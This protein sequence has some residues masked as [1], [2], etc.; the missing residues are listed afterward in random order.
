MTPIVPPY[1]HREY[2]NDITVHPNDPFDISKRVALVA[3]PFLSLHKPLSLPI[4]LG[5]GCVRLYTSLTKLIADI[6]RGSYREISFALLGTI[7]AIIALASSIFAHPIGMVITTSQDIIL[8]LITLISLIRQGN[9]EAC[10]ISLANCTNNVL[11]LTLMCVGGLELSIAS[12]A[13]QAIILII[14]SREEFKRGHYLEAAANVL[15]SC[16]RM[17][18]GCCKIKV[19]HNEQKAKQALEIERQNAIAIAKNVAPSATEDSDPIRTIYTTIS[20]GRVHIAAD[21]KYLGSVNSYNNFV[22]QFFAWIFNYSICVNFDGKL[23]SLN[24]KSYSKLIETLTLNNKVNDVKELTLFRPVAEK[25]ILPGCTWKM[26]DFI[27]RKDRQALFQKLCAAI[28]KNNSEKAILMIGK[29]AEVDS[30]YYDRES[31][32]PSFQSDTDGLKKD[33]GYYF[34]VFKA[35]PLMQAALKGNMKRVCDFLKEAGANLNIQ[36]VGYVFQRM[37]MSI[38]KGLE[39]VWKREYDTN[40]QHFIDVPEL[41]ERTI[42][43]TQDFRSSS[44]HYRLDQNTLE[45][46]AL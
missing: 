28:A 27:N 26:R 11:Y 13:I 6:N 19:L 31:L 38:D 7:I 43:N 12:L 17:Y 41:K 14:S 18:Q 45:V 4:S 3:L 15:M 32:T 23:R 21:A 39:L 40:N 2:S 37:I 10:L 25:A 20:D 42:V 34:S 30:D 24:K 9:I 44:T 33:F 46:V 5:M 8:E 1:Y 29:G 36:G 35:P 22:T 16:I